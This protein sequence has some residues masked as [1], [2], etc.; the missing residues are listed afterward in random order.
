MREKESEMTTAKPNSRLLR[1][2]LAALAYVGGTIMA[3]P[4]LPES[5]KLPVGLSALAALIYVAVVVFQIV[6]QRR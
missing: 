3:L 4:L 2:R 5:W 6:F 1:L